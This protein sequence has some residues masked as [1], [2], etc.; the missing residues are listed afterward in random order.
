MEYR[1]YAFYDAGGSIYYPPF[2]VTEHGLAVRHF[3][4]LVNDTNT[5]FGKFPGD[6]QLWEIGK[7]NDQT[8]QMT[9]MEEKINHGN[10]LQFRGNNKE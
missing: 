1:M 7:Y 3:H 8:G 6:F 9:P 4:K 10:G 2:A 5:D